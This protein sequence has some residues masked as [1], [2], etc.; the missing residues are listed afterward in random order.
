MSKTYYL[1]YAASAPVKKDVLECFNLVAKNFY[2]NPSSAH[3]MGVLSKQIVDNSRERIA[4]NINCSPNEIYFT[5]GATMS[6]NVVI[7]G[8]L[9]RDGLNAFLCSSVEH[10]DIMMVADYMH[11]NVRSNY[12]LDVDRGGILELYN[13]N[14]KLRKLS[15]LNFSV[16]VSVQ[17]ANSESGVIQPIKTISE[18]VHKYPDCYLHTDATQYLP[19][20]DVDV[21]ELGIDMMSM[22]GQKLGGIKGSGFLYVRE[23]IE[24][25]PIIFGEQGLIGG[26]YATP[27]IASLAE[28]TCLSKTNKQVLEKRRDYLLSKLENLEGVLVGDSY[29]RLPNN[30]YIRFPGVR[31]DTLIKLRTHTRDFSHE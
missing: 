7:Q 12:M 25:V 3:Q 8:F 30:I 23:G 28:A 16:L 27:L 5:S 11:G 14:D 9:R 21:D 24:L 29:H 22:S 17:I 26:T 19:Y 4:T 15:A 20:Y 2:A 18:I 1:D 13:L 10:D 6:N 31:G